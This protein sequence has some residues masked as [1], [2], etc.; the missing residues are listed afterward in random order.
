MR[1][2]TCQP[3]GMVSLTPLLQ[4]CVLCGGLH[5]G[6]LGLF[7]HLNDTNGA[8]VVSQVLLCGL[9]TQAA[10]VDTVCVWR[11]QAQAEGSGPWPSTARITQLEQHKDTSKLMVSAL[12]AMVPTKL[13]AA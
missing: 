3:V 2:S 12:Y 13:P 1:S 6:L 9:R 11:L 7:V 10:D 8:K 4:Q 5:L